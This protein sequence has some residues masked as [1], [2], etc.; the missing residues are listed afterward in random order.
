MQPAQITAPTAPPPARVGNA[1]GAALAPEA[2][3]VARCRGGDRVALAELYRRQRPHLLR[4]ARRILGP[5]SGD[6]EDLAQDVFI[7][8]LRSIHAFRGQSRLSTWMYRIALNVFL[9]QLRRRR[10]QPAADEPGL[11][12]APDRAATPERSLEARE[13]IEAVSRILDRMSA[14]KRLVF[15]LSEIEGRRPREI[16]RLIGT[17]VLTVRTRLHYA[18][19][20]FHA[21]A[22]RDRAVELAEP[23]ATDGCL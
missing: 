15:V 14:K 10:P 21:G 1:A 5:D 7:E 8:V 4:A 3:L 12:E 13:R 22:A 20:E 9:Q 2:E 16:A 23:P 11:P 18:R 19:K 17:P 6:G